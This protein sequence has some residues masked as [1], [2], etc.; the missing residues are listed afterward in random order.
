MKS[1]VK[2]RKVIKY[3]ILLT[4]TAVFFLVVLLTLLAPILEYQRLEVSSKFYGIL[5]NICHQVPT[6]CLWIKTSNMAL[7]ARCFFIY[8]TLFLAG[9]FYFKYR[10]TRIYWKTAFILIIPCIL[11]GSSQY[12]QLRL[13]NNVLRSITGAL[14][15]FGIG[16]I[17]FPLYYKFINFTLERR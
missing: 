13:S 14:G 3:I 10:I 15:G 1:E 16:M 9:I 12:M 11:D 7:C 6:R 8:L 4:P 5:H 17:F 2:L